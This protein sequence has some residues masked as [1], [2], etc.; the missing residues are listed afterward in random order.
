MAKGKGKSTQKKREKFK[1]RH[2]E[3]RKGWS[4]RKRKAGFKKGAA[5]TAYVRQV[6][7]EKG[8]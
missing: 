7:K 6:L 4:Q 1:G 8:I 2:P 3:G 5:E